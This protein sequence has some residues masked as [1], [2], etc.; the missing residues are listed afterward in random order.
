[1]FTVFE[2]LFKTSKLRNKG[3][4]NQQNNALLLVFIQNYGRKTWAQEK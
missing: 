3:E 4:K 1:M 2:L